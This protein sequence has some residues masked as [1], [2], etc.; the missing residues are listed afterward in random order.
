MFDPK[1][2][3]FL[4]SWEVNC[5]VKKGKA[6]RGMVVVESLLIQGMHSLAVRYFGR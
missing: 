1:S 5:P 2:K 3:Q 6:V 4:H